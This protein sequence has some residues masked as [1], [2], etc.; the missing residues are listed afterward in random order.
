MYN[1]EQPSEVMNM[2]CPEI[3][4]WETRR[5]WARNWI[6]RMRELMPKW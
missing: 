3:V 5:S 4:P 6:V 1:R 2:I